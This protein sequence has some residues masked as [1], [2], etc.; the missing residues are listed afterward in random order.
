MSAKG[1]LKRLHTKQF[2]AKVLSQSIKSRTWYL[3]AEIL[4][5]PYPLTLEDKY[6]F[7]MQLSISK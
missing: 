7:I 2:C 1:E 5:R 3:L 6:Q 4:E